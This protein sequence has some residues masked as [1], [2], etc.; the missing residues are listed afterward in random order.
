[1]WA[2]PKRVMARAEGAAKATG[3]TLKVIQNPDNAYEPIKRNNTLLDL[4]RAN[5]RTFGVV[6]TPESRERMGSSDVGN[7]SQVIPAIQP[8]VQIAPAGT[9]IHSRACEQAAVRPLAC[10]G[11]LT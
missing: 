8:T 3:T 10:H 5:A 11:M 4:F 1:M 6:E 7:V 9:P 2:L